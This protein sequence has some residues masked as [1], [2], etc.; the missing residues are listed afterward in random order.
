[1]FWEKGGLTRSREMVQIKAIIHVPDV[2]LPG[3]IRWRI[4]TTQLHLVGVAEGV[5]IAIAIPWDAIHT[6][7]ADDSVTQTFASRAVQG[8]RTGRVATLLP[9][10]GGLAVS[11]QTLDAILARRGIRFFGNADV[12]IT[13]RIVDAVLILTTAIKTRPDVLMTIVQPAVLYVLDTF[14]LAIA[15]QFMGSVQVRIAL[16]FPAGL[17]VDRKNARTLTTAR[18]RACRSIPLTLV[19][20]IHVQWDSHTLSLLACECTGFTDSAA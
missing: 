14:P 8:M 4:L 19:V 9:V 5:A 20:G 1:V 17:A 11:A 18:S 12:V 13:K 2:F 6:G 10:A 3:D 16:G 15:N 7:T